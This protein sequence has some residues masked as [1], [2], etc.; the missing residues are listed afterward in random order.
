M[1][2]EVVLDEH[3]LEVGRL[4]DVLEHLGFSGTWRAV[5][6]GWYLPVTSSAREAA[7]R[8]V[9][10]LPWE[11]RVA[12]AWLAASPGA[13]TRA[14]VSTSG[15][16]KPVTQLPELLNE[17]WDVGVSRPSSV[18]AEA[19]K[20][21]CHTVLAQAWH[22]L[23]ADIRLRAFC[24]YVPGE[25]INKY[26]MAAA[27]ET[28]RTLFEVALVTIEAPHHLLERSL[29]LSRRPAEPWGPSEGLLWTLGWRTLHLLQEPLEI[30]ALNLIGVAH[31]QSCEECSWR[32]APRSQQC[33]AYYSLDGSFELSLGQALASITRVR[34]QPLP[35]ALVPSGI[36]LC[37]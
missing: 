9:G 36:Y 29:L 20:H 33:W 27:V 12:G 4:H 16:G 1:V 7:L 23:S 32:G 11:E 30:S 26:A 22:L 21:G 3:V 37:S 31:A 10:R 17:G 2:L 19:L 6:S 28:S 8:L 15:D 34:L 5:I 25:S 13:S 35:G 24:D 14:V 18:G